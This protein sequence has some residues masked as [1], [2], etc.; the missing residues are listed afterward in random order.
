[1]AE[2]EK[3]EDGATRTG[4]NVLMLE[5]HS[6]NA[7]CLKSSLLCIHKTLLKTTE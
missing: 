4:T 1:M 2:E 7:V 5:V 3:V 6:Y